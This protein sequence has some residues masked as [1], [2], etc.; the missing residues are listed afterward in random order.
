MFASVCCQHSFFMISRKSNGP[1]QQ[2]C[3]TKIKKACGGNPMRLCC[4]TVLFFLSSFCPAE[5]NKIFPDNKISWISVNEKTMQGSMFDGDVDTEFDGWMDS[6]YKH[7][8]LANGD[9][10]RMG[11]LHNSP[12]ARRFNDGPGLVSEGEGKNS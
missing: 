7:F 12:F 6:T 1:C 8:L 3:Q 2:I 9:W 11:W 5:L 4:G 10:A